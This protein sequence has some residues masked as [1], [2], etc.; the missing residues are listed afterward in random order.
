MDLL[1]LRVNI[2]SNIEILNVLIHMNLKNLYV[3]CVNLGIYLINK[4][5]VYYV[6]KY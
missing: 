5:N 3:I 2:M 4:E 1:V 6:L